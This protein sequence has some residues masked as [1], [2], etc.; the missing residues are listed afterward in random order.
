MLPASKRNFF[1]LSE[2]FWTKKTLS[3]AVNDGSVVVAVRAVPA[4]LTTTKLLPYP[5]RVGIL[6]KP[7]VIR[8]SSARIEADVAADPVEGN[9]P[10]V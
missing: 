6:S 3:V 4:L 2:L 1:V 5:A 10:W 8:S 7:T 9:D